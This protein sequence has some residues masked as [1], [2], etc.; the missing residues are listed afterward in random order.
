M[1]IDLSGQIIWEAK[2]NCNYETF[3]RVCVFVGETNHSAC[4][5]TAGVYVPVAQHYVRLSCIYII[6]LFIDLF[7]QKQLNVPVNELNP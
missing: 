3:L 1:T 5:A 7:V 6:F 2:T 4:N